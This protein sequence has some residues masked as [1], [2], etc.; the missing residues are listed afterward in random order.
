METPKNE[1]N[2]LKDEFR[3]L[4]DNLKKVVGGAWESEERKKL[5]SEIEDGLRELG[6]VL[7]SVADDFHHG[8]AGQNFRRGVDDFSERVRSG[9]VESKAR[10][11]ILHALQSLN[12]ELEKAAERFTPKPPEDQ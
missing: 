10:Q 4:G 3:N 9:E 6:D 12:A 7:N 2:S 11:G 5:Q 8:E 1:G